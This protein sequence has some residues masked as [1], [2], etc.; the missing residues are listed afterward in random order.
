MAVDIYKILTKY[1]SKLG[2]VLK[3]E[4]GLLSKFVSEEIIST[5]D[6]DVINK[7]NLTRKGPKLVSLI[8]G[9]VKSGYTKG[10]FTMLHIM[11][12]HGR[13]D[14]REIADK[15]LQEC[16]GVINNQQPGIKTSQKFQEAADKQSI[17]S[18]K[19]CH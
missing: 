7:E 14:T 12:S 19:L 1:Y 11:K 17:D 15:I 9:P 10:F 2:D 4:D 13:P 5:D 18:G 16:G 3:H 8:C 6:E